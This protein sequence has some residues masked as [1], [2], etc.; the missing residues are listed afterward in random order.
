MAT[1][2]KKTGAARKRPVAPMLP[3]S[4]CPQYVRLRMLLDSA[5]IGSIRYYLNGTNPAEKNK[6]FETLEP[7][8]MR[9]IDLV[10]QGAKKIP[11][12]PGYSNCDG[13]CVPYQCYYGG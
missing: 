4:T 9:I 12:P 7:L 8:L 10:W 11:C 5:E 3:D 1:K 2:S 13:V 6:N